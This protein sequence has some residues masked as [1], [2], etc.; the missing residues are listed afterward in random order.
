MIS[1]HKVSVYWAPAHDQRPT[2]DYIRKLQPNVI[3]IMTEDVQHISDAHV[4]APDAIIIPRIWRIDDDSGRAVRE[5]NENPTEAGKRHAEQMMDAIATMSDQARERGLP[6]PRF[7]QIMVGGANE[8]NAGATYPVI[9][10]YAL[11]FGHRVAFSDFRGALLCILG[12]GHPATPPPD[13]ASWRDFKRLAALKNDIPYKDHWIETHGYWQMEGPHNGEDYEWLAG[14]HHKCPLPFPHF[15]GEC[16]VDGGIYDRNPRY[17]WQDYHLTP[18]QYSEQ[19]KANHAALAD[20]VVGMCIFENDY[21]DREWKGFDVTRVNDLIV[22]WARAYDG[23]TTD[24]V[25]L[26]VIGNGDVPEPSFGYFGNAVEFV[27]RWEGGYVNNPRDPGGETN[28]GISKRAHPDEDIA[29]MTRERAIEIYRRHYWMPVAAA[30]PYPLSLVYFDTAVLHGPGAAATWFKKYGGKTNEE[31]NLI[32]GILL[33]RSIV[34]LRSKN[35]EEFADGW[36]ARLLD[37]ISEIEK[38]V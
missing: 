24:D 37:L 7:E 5:M 38:D 36:T 30:L 9:C 19:C 14:R 17:G 35:R 8:P 16:G 15:I 23:G 29:N 34:Y 20:N 12:V 33:E 32:H 13:Q 10:D 21:Q 1:K 4:A 3:R 6:F 22:A 11:A 18:E 28:F 31:W 25:Y 27:L 2:L 26:P